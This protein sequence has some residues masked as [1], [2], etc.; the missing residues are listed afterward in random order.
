M[1][2]DAVAAE[3]DNI[4]VQ[5]ALAALQMRGVQ[6]VW[7][8]PAERAAAEANA[9]SLLDDAV[10]ARPRSI[11]VLQ[12]YCRYLNATN[13]FT[14][15]LVACAR[16]VNLDP[17]DG[18]SLYL[19]GLGQL[20]LGRFEDSLA[21]FRQAERYDTP[22]VSRWTW[23]LGAGLANVMLGRNEEAVGD[24]LRSIAITPAS[25]RSYLMLAV[26]YQRL[27]RL[28]DA[29][30]ALAKGLEVRPTSTVANFKVPTKNASSR[31]IEAGEQ[32]GHTLTALGL[33]EG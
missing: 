7:Y 25:G 9:K 8:E 22:A 24:I 30:A 21:T 20:S 5:V 3:P 19:I 11:P 13:Q 33:P 31:F 4:D 6:M 14:E 12:A 28:D 26:A 17:W 15:S 32:I 10:K 1:L 29:K 2:E 27:G 16:A 18:T 23:P